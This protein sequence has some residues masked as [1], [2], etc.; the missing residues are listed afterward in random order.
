V[1]GTSA[2]LIGLLLLLS[3]ISW[4]DNSL[5]S[6][7]LEAKSRPL[8]SGHLTIR[9]PAG[10]MPVNSET[11]VVKLGESK[12]Q[13]SAR[14]AF[15]LAGPDFFEQVQQ[16]LGASSAQLFKLVGFP[17]AFMVK[18]DSATGS[19][20]SVYLWHVD[21]SVQVVNFTV[22]APGS[23]ASAAI[24]LA[25][26]ITDQTRKIVAIRGNEQ[27][28]RQSV[29]LKKDYVL[30]E[31]LSQNDY[32]PETVWKI[33]RLVPFKVVP[34]LYIGECGH[35]PGVVVP[36]VELA[37]RSGPPS[38]TF[39][40]QVV[41]GKLL[42]QPIEWQE[43]TTPSMTSCSAITTRQA[44]LPYARNPKLRFS[45]LMRARSPERMAELTFILES[46]K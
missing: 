8:L 23:S 13:V 45:A 38:P 46:V 3:P 42:G 18:H 16:S 26:K 21:G 9:I 20:W 33:Y 19:E 5:Q 39:S 28:I 27:A 35:M 31:E 37:L 29:A 15:A 30:I 32:G 10:A 14:E 25:K 41:A 4:A 22:R 2:P 40:R 1:T 7:G 17:Q 11:I 24:Q 34:P 6:D 12:I 44:D 36:D 43:K